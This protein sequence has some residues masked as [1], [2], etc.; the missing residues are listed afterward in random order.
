MNMKVIGITGGIASG[1][2]TVKDM[3]VKM[4]FTVIDSD[5]IATKLISIGKEHYFRIVEAFGKSI[6]MP[7]KEINRKKLGEIIFHNEKEKALLNAIIHPEVKRLIQVEIEHQDAIGT[8]ILFVDV[9]LLYES[10]FEN[11]FE[12]VILVYVPLDV[13]I[14]RL[15]WR[16]KI[17]IEYAMSKINSQIPLDEKRKRADYIIDNSDSIIATK[18]QLMTILKEI[19]DN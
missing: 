8:N 18:R 6:L 4:N 11:T 15:V 7:N 9:P 10:N 16:D 12:K 1:K 5:E 14:Q 17:D 2:S 19:E 13:Q 3:L